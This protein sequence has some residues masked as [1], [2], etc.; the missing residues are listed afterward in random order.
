MKK[1]AVAMIS[2]SISMLVG[3]SMSGAA[4]VGTTQPRTLTAVLTPKAVVTVQNKPF[5]TPKSLAHATG[6]FSATVASKTATSMS[7]RLTYSNLG[8]PLL[9][10]ADIHIGPPGKF[11]RVLFRLCGP[12]KSGQKGVTKLKADMARQLIVGKHWL[13]LI[14]DKYPNGAVR[15][16]IVVK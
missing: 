10:V 14:T 4:Q 3:A 1:S 11:G 2:L 9:V 12:C 8:T 7:W 13:T 5:S 15:G 6:T 16:Q